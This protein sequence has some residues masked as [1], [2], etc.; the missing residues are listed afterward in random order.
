MRFAM[1]F[2][3]RAGLA[4][5]AA[6]MISAAWA[7]DCP[8]LARQASLP[9]TINRSGTVSVPVTIEGSDLMLTVD[10]GAYYSM[11]TQSTAEKLGLQIGKMPDSPLSVYGGIKM[12]QVAVAHSMAIGRMQGGKSEFLLVPDK[13]FRA[14]VDGLLGVSTFGAFDADF[15]FGGGKLNLISQNHCDGDVVYWTKTSPF[16]VIP[17]DTNVYAGEVK[18]SKFPKIV[19]HVQLDG[20]DITAIVDTGASIS[21]VSLETAE[22][23][24]GFSESSLK[25]RPG[26]VNNTIDRIYSYPFGKLSF[27]G[28]EVDNPEFILI[29]DEDSKLPVKAPK[30]LIGMDILRHLHMYVAYREQKL[31]LTTATAK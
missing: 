15:D 13:I 1:R 17:F 3:L 20:K 7:G 25:R 8:M 2:F 16:A 21:T 31:Y 24:F 4:V 10:T 30:M 26:K 18:K 27:G 29:S 22:S 9:L 28:I 11:L 12:K 23:L 19:V 6:A 5:A 14:A